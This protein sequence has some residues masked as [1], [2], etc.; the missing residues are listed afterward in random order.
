[1]TKV[2]EEGGGGGGG[3]RSESSGEIPQF[4]YFDL[5]KDIFPD[6]RMKKPQ[7]GGGASTVPAATNATTKGAETGTTDPSTAIAARRGFLPVRA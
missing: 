4:A 5:R 3:G 7:A 2:E 6:T 1:M